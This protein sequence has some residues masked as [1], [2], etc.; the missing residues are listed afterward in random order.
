MIAT[1][2]TRGRKK[3]TWYLQGPTI[4][5]KIT[6]QVVDIKNSNILPGATLEVFT[7]LELPNQQWDFIFQ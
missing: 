2:Y 7:Y 5:N 1:K 4:V 6:D 3:Q